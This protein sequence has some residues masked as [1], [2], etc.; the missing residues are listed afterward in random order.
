[1]SSN[2]SFLRGLALTALAASVLTLAAC[3]GQQGA[4][5][6]G[7]PAEVTV[8][9]L[10]PQA[11][12]V[13][14]ELPGRT[15]AFQIAEVRP[16][17]NG[18]VK[19][20]LFEEGALVKAGQPLYQLDDA[21]YRAENNNAKAT[22]AKAKAALYS[23]QLNAKRTSEL[24][25]IDAVSKQDDETATATWRQAEADVAAGQAQVESTGV[26]LA[27]ARIVSPITGRIGKSAVTPGALVTA[28]QADPMARVQQMDPIFIDV[29]QSSGELLD[30]RK[31][32]AAG[33]LKEADGTPVK[34]LLED[35]STYAHDGKLQFAD[36][37][38]DP[39]TGSFALRVI[40]PNPEGVLLPGMYV[41]AVL[42]KGSNPH[43]LLVPQA[44]ISRD[45]K[46][47][48]TAMVIGKDGKA[49]L[50]EVQVGRT[51]GDQWLVE[52][53]LAAGDKVIVEGLQMIQ[54]GMPVHASEAG[55]AAVAAG[56]H[57]A[58]AAH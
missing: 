3:K 13:T 31:R 39:T 26:N 54:P 4:Q 24:A 14:R 7:G 49:E 57:A 27:F 52:S 28:N 19:Q 50:R 38:V 35:G 18:I 33:S 12:T 40:V 23:A 32:I 43:G 36:V 16:Q 44:G 34:I 17:V 51:V 58:A 55:A 6:Q 45:P 53:G 5:Q 30:L 42:D 48:A 1:M 10:K 2:R 21:V 15:S 56:G 9:T 22:L 8:V 46:G 37:S 41:R 25:R 29:T 11:V 47:G 20:R